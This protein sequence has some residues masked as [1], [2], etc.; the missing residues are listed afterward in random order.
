MYIQVAEVKKGRLKSVP[1]VR[2]PVCRYIYDSWVPAWCNKYNLSALSVAERA[3]ES[4]RSLDV[5]LALGRK[6]SRTIKYWKF[7]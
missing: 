7:M 3:R 6:L 5:K 2:E 1:T 4:T